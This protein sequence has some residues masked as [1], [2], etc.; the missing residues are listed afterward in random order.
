MSVTV[1]FY[2]ILSLG[3]SRQTDP[4]LCRL[5]VKTD[6]DRVNLCIFE[7]CERA[8]V[9]VRVCVSF[10][11]CGAVCVIVVKTLWLKLSRARC[12]LCCLIGP[13]LLGFAVS[14]I[15]YIMP[16]VPRDP[17][18][19]FTAWG[20]RGSLQE[21]IQQTHF[22]GVSVYFKTSQTLHYDTYFVSW[23]NDYLISWIIKILFVVCV[24]QHRDTALLKYSG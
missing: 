15:K 7:V 5:G 10:S 6:L 23:Y 22:S 11:N 17:P 4:G 2:I 24:L 3:R 14:V 20:Q 1:R 8:C 21:N 13:V 12:S 18:P 19:I 9:C 16:S